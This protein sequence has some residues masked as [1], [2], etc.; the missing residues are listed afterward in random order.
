MIQKLRIAAVLTMLMTA[1]VHASPAEN[2]PGFVTVE[3]DGRLWVF[4]PDS[5]GL[6]EFQKAGEPGKQFT[7]IGGGPN[8]VT[9]KAADQATL[10]EYLAAVKNK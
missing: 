8:G 1:V 10:D 3:K 4:K 7:N 9:V 2:V 6:A 5:P